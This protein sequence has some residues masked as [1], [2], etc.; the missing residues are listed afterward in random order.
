M[1]DS[2]QRGIA[3]FDLGRYK[4]ALKE[5][6]ESPE[7]PTAQ[8][9]MMYSLYNLERYNESEAMA[10]SL[11]AQDPSDPDIFFLKARIE[12]QHDNDNAA[13]EYL[14]EAIS[15]YPEDADYFGLKAAIL[16]DKKKYDDA[17]GFANH[18][19]SLDAKN[20][21][22]IN[23]RAQILTKLNRKEEAGET[24]EY[25]LY[26]NPEDS[27][28]HANVGWVALEHG[29][30]K[31][32]IEHFRQALMLNP[33]MDYARSGMSTALKAKNFLYRWHLKY[34]FWI[35]K[36]SGKNQWIF[37]IGLYVGYRL[38]VSALGA[39]GLTYLA[40]PLIIV[41]LLFALGGWMINPI[42]NAILMLDKNG[43]FLL[44]KNEKTSG[45]TIFG[46]FLTAILCGTAFYATSF[47][48]FGT[49]GFASLCAMVPL[50]NSF[51]REEKKSRFF[52]MIY[53]ALMLC[54]GVFGLFV[55]PELGSIILA[56]LF[57]LV[58]FTW[59]DNF[60]K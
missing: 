29:D 19:L 38:A 37:I 14:N 11:L 5:F 46:L 27:Y 1:A 59:L 21:F 48:I 17:L 28:S 32:A 26:D 56:V 36:Q 42:S 53:G 7:N 49:I 45:L 20:R 52:A 44:D 35:S 30:H 55:V 24:V 13:L 51:L 22:C 54:V 3:L 41:Y 9:Y 15:I 2:I 58:A 33:T 18:G 60:I 25:I 57:M 50:P 47:A 43:K 4:D 23:L 6:G 40:A 10:N 16:L 12:K 8:R 39:A 31:K 34:A